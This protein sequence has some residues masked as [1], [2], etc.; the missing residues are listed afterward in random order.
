MLSSPENK[1]MHMHPHFNLQKYFKIQ[2]LIWQD[3]ECFSLF[4]RQASKEILKCAY[5]RSQSAATNAN[6]LSQKAVTAPTA[7]QNVPTAFSRTSVK[8]EGTCH[9]TGDTQCHPG[10]HWVYIWMNR[11]F[12][13]T[14]FPFQASFAF[15]S[16]G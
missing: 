16:E 11:I 13:A 6:L 15:S 4:I 1:P 8:T 9:F 10:S 5:C 12:L 14:F 7:M 2:A 3:A